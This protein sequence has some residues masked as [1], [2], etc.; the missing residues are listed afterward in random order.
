[1]D[2]HSIF[3]IHKK[4]G[5]IVNSG[6]RCAPRIFVRRAH[7]NTLSDPTSTVGSA[8]A[9]SFGPRPAQSVFCGVHAAAKSGLQFIR[10]LRAANSVRPFVPPGSYRAARFLLLALLYSYETKISCRLLFFWQSSESV[11]LFCASVFDCS[12]SSPILFTEFRW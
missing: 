6:S 5:P 7:K 8:E 4:A 1:M 11:P 2:V 9:S 12:K 3:S 10:G